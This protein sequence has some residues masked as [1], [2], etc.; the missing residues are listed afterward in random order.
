LINVA[1]GRLLVSGSPC[2]AGDGRSVLAALDVA[3]G[4]ELWRTDPMEEIWP[5]PLAGLGDGVVVR[6]SPVGLAA[7]DVTNGEVVWEA[8]G[9]RAVGDGPDYVVAVVGVGEEAQQSRTFAVLDRRTGA[10][11]WRAAIDGEYLTAAVGDS[12]VVAVGVDERTV[13][14]DARSGAMRWEAPFAIGGEAGGGAV[15]GVIVTVTTTSPV[16]VN[17]LDAATGKQM[18]S[19]AGMLSV[20]LPPQDGNVY[21]LGSSPSGLEA[22]DPR[23]G[24]S[25]WV[26]SDPG[27]LV[28][29]PTV[30]PGLVLTLAQRGFQALD[31][32]TGKMRWTR[33]EAELGLPGPDDTLPSGF[34]PAFV[35]ILPSSVGVFFASGNC[36]G[37]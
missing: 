9:L 13:G 25:R 17:A 35:G 6:G 24:V 11:R 5:P 1:D 16:N 21:L 14:Y 20:N 2:P 33:T 12:A 10:E 8:N 4:E 36:L 23:S 34:A 19:A 30:G 27:G 15:A 31:P 7:V 26:V 37:S 28:A 3:T 29:E 18:W 22:V 32:A